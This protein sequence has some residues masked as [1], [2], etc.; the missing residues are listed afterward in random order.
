ME[1][2]DCRF[3]MMQTHYC[4]LKTSKYKNHNKIFKKA[5]YKNDGCFGLKYPK[6]IR[7][8]LLISINQLIYLTCLALFRPVRKKKKKNSQKP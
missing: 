3:I 5:H 2:H 8:R 6:M 4:S 1:I 7:T